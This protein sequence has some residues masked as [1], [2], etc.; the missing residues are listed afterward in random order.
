MAVSKIIK[1]AMGILEQTNFVYDDMLKAR[2]LKRPYGFPGN[3][4]LST[5]GVI[6]KY[7]REHGIDGKEESRR[8]MTQ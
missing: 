6:K 5:A 1:R 2:G 4:R 8:H 3:K 7:N